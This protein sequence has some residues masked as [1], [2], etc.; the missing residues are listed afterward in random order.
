MDHHVVTGAPEPLE[1]TLVQHGR[2]HVAVVCGEVDMASVGALRTCLRDVLLD[3][4]VHLL[5]DLR[6]VTFMDSAG[7]GA[8]VS[9][10]KQTRVFRGSFGIVA[11]SRQ[12]RR[13]LQ[14]T[15]LD[16]VFPCF[17]SVEAAAAD[18]ESTGPASGRSMDTTVDQES[19]RSLA[20]PA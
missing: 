8:L 16:R 5:V 9:I 20:D 15:S 4:G 14:L 7:L 6:D 17:E 1:V 13:L 2:H 3:G 19:D 12:V 18:D 11:P 10:R